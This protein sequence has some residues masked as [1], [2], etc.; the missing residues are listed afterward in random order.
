MSDSIPAIPAGQ[1]PA[2]PPPLPTASHR[3]VFSGTAREYFGIWFVNLL[4][5]IVTLGIYSA[6]AKVRTE[7]YFYGNTTL[8]GAS[9]EYLAEP[10]A[11]LKGRLIAYAVAI[12]LAASA[13]FAPVVY[14]FL[15]LG[16]GLLVPV[17]IAWSLRFRA[18][19]S[20]WR[21]LTFHFDRGAGEAYP[22]FLFWVWLTGLT[23]S[24]VYPIMKQRQHAFLVEGHRYGTARFGYVGDLGKYYV[25][26]GIGA[27]IGVVVFGVFFAAMMAM[28]IAAGDTRGAEPPKA[29][30]GV[31]AVM[32]LGF[33]AISIFW[34]AR[35]TNL[36]WQSSSLGPHRFTSTLRAR[37]MMWLYG[38]NVVAILCTLGLAVPWAM[39]RL[40]RYRAEHFS[41]EAAGS[42]E[43]FVA[44]Q[45]RIYSASSAELVDV[46]DVGVDIGI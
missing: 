12:A 13:K 34:R 29:F 33:F 32:Y 11:I 31:I 1:P 4:L 22:P 39:I 40:A 37:D 27:A 16:V 46:L 7:R 20:G 36:M 8:A 3:P 45:D 38:S 43:D 9:F 21:G 42:I 14:I 18:R 2:L 5:S 41:L 15:I 26:Y 17:L 28:I 24:L 44:D 6:W 10:I 19:N 23:G 25:P 30:F 35:Y